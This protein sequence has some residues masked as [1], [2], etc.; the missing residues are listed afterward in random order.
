VQKA[1]EKTKKGG[2]MSCYRISQERLGVWVLSKG[3]SPCPE[4]SNVCEV[5]SLENPITRN[6]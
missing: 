4:K 6:L 5:N 2:G 1:A 3:W